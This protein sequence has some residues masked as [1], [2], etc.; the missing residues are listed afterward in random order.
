M[1]QPDEDFLIVEDRLDPAVR[2]AE[3]PPEDAQEQ[4]TVANPADEPVEPRV[5]FETDEA[6]AIDQATIVNLDDDWDR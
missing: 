3:A 2:D 6:D 1:T 5:P 4:A